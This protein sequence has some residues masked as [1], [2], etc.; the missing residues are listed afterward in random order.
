MQAW[1]VKDCPQRLDFVRQGEGGAP[2]ALRVPPD[3]KSTELQ[4][5]YGEAS[6]EPTVGG[7][8]AD[9]RANAEG[10][11][12]LARPVGVPSNERVVRG[13]SARDETVFVGAGVEGVR[14]AL[15]PRPR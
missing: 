5:R 1:R 6:L 12:F 13:R 4:G 15:A 2:T 10:E 8:R 9:G 14:E 7:P 11:R 3:A